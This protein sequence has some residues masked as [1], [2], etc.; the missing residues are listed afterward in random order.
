MEVLSEPAVVTAVAEAGSR[1]RLLTFFTRGQGGVRLYAKRLPRR[2]PATT[3]VEPLQGGELLF[4]RPREGARGRL[5]SFVPQ[6]VWPGIRGDLF[7]IAH[8]LAFCELLSIMLAEGESQPEVFAV[9]VQFLDRLEGEQRPGLARAA[10]TLRLLSLGGF[11]PQLLS[12]AGCGS[13][14][15]PGTGVIFSPDE[16]GILCRECLT[17]RRA[18]A[19]P[20][21]PAAIGFLIRTLTLPPGP[22]RRLRVA[23]LVEREVLRLLDRY[24][25]ARAGVRP[26]AGATIERLEG[27]VA[28]AAWTSGAT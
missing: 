11:A 22:A 24:V 26:R 1:E 19:I 3:F 21:S 12:C 17:G 25:E 18:A 16:G 10:G 6:R 13:P 27:T 28:A 2:A 4:S 7:R 14:Q 5:L 15:S 8:G 9:L 20:V 23:P